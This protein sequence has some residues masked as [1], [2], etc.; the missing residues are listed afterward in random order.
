MMS[1]STTPEN[2]EGIS[3]CR[4][5]R[6]KQKSEKLSVPQRREVESE[7]VDTQVG[8]VEQSLSGTGTQGGELVRVER[9]NRSR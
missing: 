4:E 7:T 8:K 1:R 9:V 2:P 5:G 6:A 3:A